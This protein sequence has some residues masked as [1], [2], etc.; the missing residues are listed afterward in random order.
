VAVPVGKPGLGVNVTNNSTSDV[1]V[2]LVGANA[3]GAATDVGCMEMGTGVADI[4]RTEG[5]LAAGGWLIP[6]RMSREAAA[7]P[8]VAI[9]SN[10]Q[11]TTIKLA[12]DLRATGR[13]SSI[14]R[15]RVALA[16]IAVP[17]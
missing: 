5:V 4:E 11:P 7:P 12:L 3:P 17:S 2:G 9:T 6:R 10:I 14:T 1:A 13:G 8:A 15:L 16:T